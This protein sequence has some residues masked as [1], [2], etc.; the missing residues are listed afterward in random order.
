MKSEEDLRAQFDAELRVAGL[1]LSGEDRERLFV[2]WADHLPHRQAL[3]DAAARLEEEPTF[4]EKPT[5][6][7][8]SS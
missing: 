7:G 2:M 8:A 3:R 5:T 6:S 4:L 1:E